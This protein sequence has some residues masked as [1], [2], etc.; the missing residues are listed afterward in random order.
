MENQKTP[1]SENRRK[2]LERQ[3]RL[4]IKRR[5]R[6]IIIVCCEIIMMLVLAIACYA[7]NI[8]NMIQRQD[9]DNIQTADFDNTQAVTVIQ[10]VTD[11]AGEIETVET[12]VSQEQVLSG[13]TNIAVFGVDARMDEGLT[14]GVNG[15]VIMICSINNATG[16]IKL[17]SIARDMILRLMGPQTYGDYDKA[18]SQLAYTDVGDELSMINKNFDLNIERYVVVNWAA[19]A[20][21]IDD[22]GGV[23]DV[24]IFSEEFMIL[25]NSYTDSVN[26]ETGIWAPELTS[27]GVQ[28]L[29]GTQAVAY[30]RVR[31]G[32]ENG[33][34]DRTAHQREVVMKMFNKAKN[35]LVSGGLDEKAQVLNAAKGFMSN[36][37]TNLSFEEMFSLINRAANLNLTDESTS[38]IPQDYVTAEYVGNLSV[39]D[40]VVARDLEEEV[41][42]LHEFLFGTVNYVPTNDVK[43]IS[44]DIKYLSG[45]Y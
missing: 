32:L 39:P 28:D 3:R 40:P 45:L 37:A 11:E 34:F 19:V 33:D 20:K 2:R 43:A 18:N 44:D 26:R 41:S 6:R 42:Y 27:P 5:R 10:N 15:D 14:S 8:L 29:M 22:L 21:A 7:V 4:R 17:V 23:P 38:S 9:F 25:V 13:Y 1:Q 36:I 31:Y 16:E 24:D 35:M 12:V 30:C